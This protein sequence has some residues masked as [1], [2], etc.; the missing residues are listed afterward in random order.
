MMQRIFDSHV[1]IIDPQFELVENNG[2]LPDHYTV[3]KYLSELKELGLEAS[4]VRLFRG[5][6]KAFI[7]ITLLMQSTS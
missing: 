4:G 2:F 5:P 6:S 1:H 7:K 3:E